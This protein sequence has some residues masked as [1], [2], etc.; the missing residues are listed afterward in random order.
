MNYFVIRVPLSYLN[1]VEAQYY[2][3]IKP[4]ES[5]LVILCQERYPVDLKVIKIILDD[6]LWKE[7]HYVSYNLSAFRLSQKR[8]KERNIFC[9]YSNNIILIKQ[10]VKE[11]NSVKQDNQTASRVFIGNENTAS[12]RHIVNSIKPEEIVIID[13][14][15]AVINNFAEKIKTMKGKFRSFSIRDRMKEFF[16]K[17][18]FGYKLQSLQNVLYFSSYKIG[19]NNNIRIDRNTYGKLRLDLSKQIPVKQVLFLGQPM[20]EHSYMDTDVYVDC[21]R[22]IKKYY[23]SSDF[24]YCPHRDEHPRN[25][26]RLKSEL[27]LKIKYSELPIEYRLAKEKVL[28]EVIAAFYS[29]ALQ[30]FYH[31]FDGMVK[32]ESFKIKSSDFACDNKI[33]LDEIENC[34]SYLRTLESETFHVTK[35]PLNEKCN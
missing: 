28:P 10:F 32:V 30:N 12:M 7:I 6:S 24:I 33:K 35:M 16:A 5:I 2:Y 4:E 29:S 3:K 13:E 15:F 14:G 19:N 27:G 17:Q 25:L 11:L 9:K 1:A 23:S 26:E 34:Y 18:I 8:E 21:I 20:I 22:Q 31:M